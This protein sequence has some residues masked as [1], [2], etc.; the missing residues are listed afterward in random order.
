MG[1]KRKKKC[2]DCW[3]H[4]LI[5]NTFLG[6]C[7]WFKEHGKKI[8]EIPPKTIDVGCKFFKKK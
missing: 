8:K 4:D 6:K 1:G 5:G 7:L 2:W 3:Y